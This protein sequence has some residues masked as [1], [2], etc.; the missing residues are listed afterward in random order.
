[1]FDKPLF[2]LSG[3]ADITETDKVNQSAVGRA[4]V[5]ALIGITQL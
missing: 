1:M 2:M 3:A 5:T 4:N